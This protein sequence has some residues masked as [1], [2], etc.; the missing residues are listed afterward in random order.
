MMN[1][2]RYAIYTRRRAREGVTHSLQ[3]TISIVHI[4]QQ[5]LKLLAGMNFIH[6]E[7]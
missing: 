7:R 6:A 4:L 2:Q 5:A 1:T 3:K